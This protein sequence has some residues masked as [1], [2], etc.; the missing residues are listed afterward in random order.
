[1]LNFKLISALCLAAVLSGAGAGAVT[2]GAL[3]LPKAEKLSHSEMLQRAM[4]M[5]EDMRSTLASSVQKRDDAKADGDLVAV[6]CVGLNLEAMRGLGK[7][8]E[9]A[10]KAMQEALAEKNDELVNHEW[11]KIQIAKSQVD[12]RKGRVDECVG[13]NVHFTGQ[14]SAEASIDPDIRPDDP[15]DDE[16]GAFDSIFADQPETETPSDVT[17]SF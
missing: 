6:N 5:V 16:I 9:L 1:M 12:F 15:T 3:P 17:P 14:F 10:L 8:S 4:G 11:Q 13:E 7:I 2:T